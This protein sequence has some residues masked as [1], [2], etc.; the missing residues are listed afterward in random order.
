MNKK[1]QNSIAQV[2]VSTHKNKYITFIA[3]TFVQ[4]ERIAPTNCSK[5]A[6][7]H[8]MYYLI[9]TL[10]LWTI[11][12]SDCEQITFCTYHW[13]YDKEC[14]DVNY[15]EGCKDLPDF[16][17]WRVSSVYLPTN[18]TYYLF[19]D[20]TSCKGKYRKLRSS[21]RDLRLVGFVRRISSFKI[22]YRINT[23]H[24]V[25][26]TLIFEIHFS[27]L[28]LGPT[29]LKW[30]SLLM[31]NIQRSPLCRLLFTAFQIAI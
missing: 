16:L 23:T 3:I 24:Q 29:S 7:S 25:I 1:F 6:C 31:I 27:K 10:C 14:L 26:L 30:W 21:W 15:T 19:Y 18:D 4:A 8:K 22:A 17:R 13:W 2:L 12:F 28:F 11:A 9:T 5:A 20:K